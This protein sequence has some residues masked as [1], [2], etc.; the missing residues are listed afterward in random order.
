M[1]RF[2]R[3]KAG[4][5][6]V[7]IVII[8]ICTAILA[9]KLAPYDPNSVTRDR[10]EPPSSTHFFGTDNVGKDVFSGAVYGA[11]ISLTVGILAASS[12]MLL[13]VLVGSLAGYYGGA[14][15][16][17]LMRLSEL[18]QIMPRFFLALVV[19]AILGGGVGL[20]IAVIGIVSWPVTARIVRAEFLVLKE[21]EFVESAR[22]LGFHSR[23]IILSE[24]L[25][26]ALP[27]AIV[28]GTLE[29]ATAIL[30]EA[31]LS[32]F[33]LGYAGVASWGQMLN[34]AQSYLR[35]AWWLSV[36]PGGAIFIAVLA[37]NL[38]GDALNDALNPYLKER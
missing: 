10:L 38:V 32:F 34:R 37:F 1:D 7:V 28:R 30:I 6:G 23:Y 26:N 25:P 27:P 33:G 16:S 36:F 12:S 4:V 3:S 15:D 5:I 22:A 18:F 35:A 24:I 20:T 11:R 31:S 13:G 29:I 17:F 21:Q 2:K 14:L 9:P 19:V 8:L